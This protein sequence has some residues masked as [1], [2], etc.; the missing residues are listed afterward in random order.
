ME[1]VRQEKLLKKMQREQQETLQKKGVAPNQDINAQENSIT[2]I[3]CKLEPPFWWKHETE[4]SKQR[5]KID[6]ESRVMPQPNQSE[7]R[8]A[9]PRWQEEPNVFNQNLSDPCK[10]R[11]EMALY[12]NLCEYKYL[13]YKKTN[14]LIFE[15][16]AKLGSCKLAF[17]VAQ[18]KEH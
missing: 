8:V 11:A 4:E 12:V 3:P 2:V 6:E 10:R 14:T 16:T 5:L 7:Y 18:L 1:E 9:F 17:F 15:A 13:I